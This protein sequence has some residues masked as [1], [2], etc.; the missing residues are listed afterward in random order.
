[1]ISITASL[2]IYKYE[3]W[4]NLMTNCGNVNLSKGGTRVVTV[5]SQV[6]LGTPLERASSSV[7]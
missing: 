6:L 4:W 2:H 7:S 3:E 1:M 5:T